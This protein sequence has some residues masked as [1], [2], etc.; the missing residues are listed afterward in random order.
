[1]TSWASREVPI[2]LNSADLKHMAQRLGFEIPLV[3]NQTLTGHIDILQIRNGK[4]HIVG[5]KPGAKREKPIVQLMVYGICIGTVTPNWVTTV[6]LRVFLVR[7]AP[8]L[9]IFPVAGR[10]QGRITR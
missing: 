8:L 9:R 5:Y 3:S 6:R 10:T 2:Y 1:M 7:R 4:I